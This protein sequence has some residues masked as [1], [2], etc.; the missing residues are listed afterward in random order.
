MDSDIFWEAYKEDVESWDV[1][2]ILKEA[3]LVRKDFN[4]GMID[5]KGYKQ[6]IEILEGE[7][8]QKM[9]GVK[10]PLSPSEAYDRAMKGI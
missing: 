6:S 10:R 1:D 5:P 7:L 4:E 3:D 9:Y 2:R 8:Y